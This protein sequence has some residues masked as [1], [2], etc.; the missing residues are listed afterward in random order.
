MQGPHGDVVRG[1]LDLLRDYWR[2]PR[3]GAWLFSGKPKIN[4]ISPRQLN[5]AFTSAK[6]IAGVKKAATLHR[7]GTHLLDEG[8]LMRV[9]ALLCVRVRE[10]SALKNLP[11]TKPQGFWWYLWG[12]RADARC[13]GDVSVLIDAFHSA[14]HKKSA[15]LWLGYVG[16]VCWN[17]IGKPK[18]NSRGEAKLE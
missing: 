9:P 15:A 4:P 16:L 17:C 10:G 18:F 13:D 6:N 7:I 1:V 14:G 11:R 2:E 12:K 3:P 5:R 8:F